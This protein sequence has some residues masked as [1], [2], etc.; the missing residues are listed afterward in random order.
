MDPSSKITLAEARK[1]GKLDEFIAE[2]EDSPTPIRKPLSRLLQWPESRNQSRK[3]RRRIVPKIE[4]K[5]CLLGILP[6]V[7][8]A[9]VNVSAFDHAL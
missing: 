3:H 1:E 5:F 8:G 4:A 6:Q 7:F 9:H 2:R